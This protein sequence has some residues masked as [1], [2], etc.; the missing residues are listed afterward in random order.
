MS[1]IEILIPVYNN[2]VLTKKCLDSIFRATSGNF[3]IIIVDDNSTDPESI[4]YYNS[5][6]KNKKI[7]I[8]K[9]G[10]NLGF[11]KSI[12]HGLKYCTAEYLVIMNNDVLVS[13]D[14]LQNLAKGFKE[15][16][17]IGIVAPLINCNNPYQNKSKTKTIYTEV[18]YVYGT[19]FMI[20]RRLLKENMMFDDIF[21]PGYFEDID[22]CFKVI[23]A[24]YKILVANNSKIKHLNCGTF[25]A[26]QA[27]RLIKQNYTAF[28]YRWH[29]TLFFSY[30]PSY[31]KFDIDQRSFGGDFWQAH[32][33]LVSLFFKITQKKDILKIKKYLNDQ[34]YK[35]F[36]LIIYNPKKLDI[37]N[38]SNYSTA[39]TNKDIS[40]NKHRLPLQLK[41]GKY[42]IN[43]NN[44]K[45]YDLT[46]PEI[47]VQ[48]LKNT[49]IEAMPKTIT[50]RPKKVP[51]FSFQC[52]AYDLRYIEE[53]IESVLKQTNNNW[54]LLI[55]FDNPP[56]QKKAADLI[57][58]Y[59]YFKKIKFFKNTSNLGVGP[60]RQIL[61]SKSTSPYIIPLDSDDQIAPTLLAEFKK[62]IS[63]HKDFSLIRAGLR[64]TSEIMSLEVIPE[65][66]QK[67]QGLT[68]DIYNIYQP[69]LIN[70]KYLKKI[71]GWHWNQE[72]LNACED[73]DLIIRLEELAPVFIIPKILYFKKQHDQGLT[74]KMTGHLGQRA[75]FYAVDLMLNLRKLINL[76]FIN[77]VTY[78]H[79]DK[80]IT[81]NFYL[82]Y[83]N[84][85]SSHSFTVPFI[86]AI[87]LFPPHRIKTAEIIKIFGANNSWQDLF[88]Y[89]NPTLEEQIPTPD[90]Q[91]RLAN[92]RIPFT[93]KYQLYELLGNNDIHY[94]PIDIILLASADLPTTKKSI[95]AI[96]LKTRYLFNLIILDRNI[97]PAKQEYYSK[98]QKK[99]CNLKVVT[100]PQ[101]KSEISS[102]NEELKK[103]QSPYVCLIS[104][105]IIGPDNWLNKLKGGFNIRQEIGIVGPNYA[106]TIS[107]ARKNNISDSK[108]QLTTYTE[109]NWLW[110]S[111]LLVKKTLFQKTGNLNEC[112]SENNIYTYFDLCFR[113][114]NNGYEI[115][116]ADKCFI[117]KQNSNSL[118]QN[119]KN[120]YFVLKNIW[121]NHPLFKEIPRELTFNKQT[122]LFNHNKN[123]PAPE[124]NNSKI[125]LAMIGISKYANISHQVTDQDNLKYLKKYFDVTLIHEEFLQR[126]LIDFFNLLTTENVN[127]V[128]INVT[129]DPYPLFTYRNNNNLPIGFIV[130]PYI[131]EPW[132]ERYFRLATEAKNIDT[133]LSF[134][135]YLKSSFQQISLNFDLLE[136]VVP[137]NYSEYPSGYDQNKELIFAYC[138]RLTPA[139]NLHVF[140]GLLSTIKNSITFKLNIICPLKNLTGEETQYLKFLQH[141]IKNLALEKNVVFHGD[142]ALE[143]NKR[144]LILNKSNVLVF[145]STDTGETFGRAIIEGMAAGC[146]II[147]TNWQAVKELVR[148]GENGFLV[149]TANNLPDT[150]QLL[151]AILL[152]TNHNIRQAIQQINKQKAAKFDYHCQIPK[153]VSCLK[154][155]EPKKIITK[156]INWQKEEEALLAK[157]PEHINKYHLEFALIIENPKKISTFTDLNY[158]HL[159]FGSEFC[160]ELIP[161]KEKI[162]EFLDYCL[163]NKKK[164]VLLTPPLSEKGLKK[165]TTLLS[166]LPANCEIVFNDWGLLALIKKYHLSPR[167]GRLLL[168]V[169]REPRKKNIKNKSIIEYL[170]TSNLQEKIFQEYL[171]KNNITAVELDNIWQGYNNIL[172]PKE[173][174]NS[175]YL[176]YVYITTTSKCLFKENNNCQKKCEENYIDADLRKYD[177]EKIL[178]SGNAQ[179]YV[180]KNLLKFEELQKLKISR[181]V[182][183]PK[184]R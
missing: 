154:N 10:E 179:F 57:E 112:F 104:D 92:S 6:K 158:T 8:I 71:G 96:Y 124:K 32:R 75:L 70:A 53:T 126:S 155:K 118:N 88:L 119:F 77:F 121:K 153:L 163:K 103:T 98:L 131:F 142:L 147:T 150:R 94:K 115:L 102:I 21:G 60:T 5:L 87:K 74:N 106:T 143:Q 157:L 117:Y 38:L 4:T 49:R 26:E 19:C 63:R 17:N 14:W 51:C 85:Y 36:N 132:R 108:K 113:A 2:H 173:F 123:I 45:F 99:Y 22:L 109:K 78:N 149:D 44:A 69:Y 35:N 28:Y 129:T 33:P 127:F 172:L 139:K 48:I 16:Q 167:L 47:C 56:D 116:L 156:S 136:M 68:I 7:K 152:L 91:S 171:I 9:N 25:G 39:I 145:L 100:A 79:D 12:N 93:K 177:N 170:Q 181:I 130:W 40:T 66:R 140:L 11:I 37:I 122:K 114:R 184:F 42:L 144:N 27:A 107:A 138:G 1:N 135:N 169:K 82:K 55:C 105:C 76:K 165:I 111:C 80:G 23:E 83:Y 86:S 148:D 164:P 125:K 166:I 182:Y 95:A 43:F 137:L 64:I 13:K 41:T 31:L 73:A 97:N 178:I 174:N 89:A 18:P 20:V 160:E 61:F 62:E 15:A 72:V 161:S 81:F 168:K 84:T 159:Y 30:L 59:K 101:T 146:A 54:E 110:G 65:P 67:Y 46:L 90:I 24:G 176:P 183:Q 180:N 162:K 151:N 128:F 141:T 120:D 3:S 50:C 175:I 52:P 29:K 134:S 34:I 133:F 58:K